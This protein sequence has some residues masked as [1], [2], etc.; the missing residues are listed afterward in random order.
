MYEE[1]LLYK[2]SK[3]KICACCRLNGKSKKYSLILSGNRK[4]YVC[5]GC[6]QIHGGMQQIAGYLEKKL[7]GI[8]YFNLKEIKQDA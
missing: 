6:I 1:K 4:V 5:A 8:F 7:E 3:Q 2:K